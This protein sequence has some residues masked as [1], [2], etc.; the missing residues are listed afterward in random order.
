MSTVGVEGLRR[1]LQPDLAVGV[2]GCLVAGLHVAPRVHVVVAHV[3]THAG[4]TGFSSSL[5]S[6]S[7]DETLLWSPYADTSD[8]SAPSN[9]K[10]VLILLSRCNTRDTVVLKK[11]KIGV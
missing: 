1:V 10:N 4:L 9:G 7:S 2:C 11:H 8:P 5:I 6:P 3:A